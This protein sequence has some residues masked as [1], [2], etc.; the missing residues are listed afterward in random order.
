MKE[1]R[2]TSSRFAWLVPLAVFALLLALMPWEDQRPRKVP[3]NEVPTR[4]EHRERTRVEMRTR[5]NTLRAWADDDTRYES[6]YPPDTA[7]S[8]S[9]SCAPMTSPS[10]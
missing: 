2:R 7:V 8:S 3:F 9:P 10:A 4:I 6:G 1:R 5:D